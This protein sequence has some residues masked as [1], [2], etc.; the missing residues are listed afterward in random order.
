[1]R[2]TAETLNK[3]ERSEQMMKTTLE[4][5]KGLRDGRNIHV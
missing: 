2:V 3:K 1:M 4:F 5:L